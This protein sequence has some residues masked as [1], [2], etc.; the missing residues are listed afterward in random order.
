MK[1]ITTQYFG[2]S[3]VQGSRMFARAEGGNLAV[4]NY[5][6][7]LNLDQNHAKV[8]KALYDK[9]GWNEEMVGG[10]LSKGMVWV[11]VKNSE[12]INRGIA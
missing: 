11:F 2:P 5:D 4:I 12:R 1:A 9:L 10:H 6:D 8:A 3:N 7:S